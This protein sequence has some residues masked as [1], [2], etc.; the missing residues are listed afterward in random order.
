MSDLTPNQIQT[1]LQREIDGLV[2]SNK[3]FAQYARDLEDKLIKANPAN[4][5]LLHWCPVGEMLPE[6]GDAVLVI[7]N[8]SII[9][10]TCDRF[11]DGPPFWTCLSEVPTDL[12]AVTHWSPW[13][14]VPPG[15][16]G[17]V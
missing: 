14:Q 10:A 6:A 15:L 9:P 17:A 4:T 1:L 8:G 2:E 12:T 13:P 3:G 7:D 16:K 11:K 5:T